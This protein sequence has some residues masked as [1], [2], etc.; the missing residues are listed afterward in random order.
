MDSLGVECL[1]DVENKWSDTWC[2]QWNILSHGYMPYE[3]FAGAHKIIKDGHVLILR[4]GKAY[5]MQGQEV[6]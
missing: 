4:N 3:P 1:C 5:T 6:K 2:N